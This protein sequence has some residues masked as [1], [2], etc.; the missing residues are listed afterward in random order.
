MN[1]TQYTPLYFPLI[2]TGKT[3]REQTDKLVEEYNELR[4][5]LF[6]EAGP[7]RM[8]H[9]LQ[10]VMQAYISLLMAKALELGMD[11]RQARAHITELL[12]DAN[13]L[14]RKKIERYKVERG[15][16]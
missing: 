8:L 4:K 6:A 10:D 16:T 7:D 5:E 11:E 14:H 15:W 12:E 1:S 9:E 3:P 2:I 13:Q